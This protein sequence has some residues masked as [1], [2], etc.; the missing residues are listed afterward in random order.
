MAETDEDIRAV[1]KA[2]G[3]PVAGDLSENALKVRRNLLASGIVSLFIHFTGIKL[4]PESSVLGLKFIGITEDLISGALL[5]VTSYF[6][7]HFSWYAFEGV[8]EWR[9]RVTGTKLAFLTGA[10]FTSEHGDYPDDPR[11]S[12]L[13]NWWNTNAHRIGNYRETADNLRRKIQ[14]WE[15][16]VESF[17]DGGNSLNLSNAMV[18]LNQ[19]KAEVIKLTSQIEKT[20]EILTAHRIP[21]SLNRFDSWFKLFLKSQNIRWI[22]I[23]ILIPITTGALAILFLVNDMLKPFCS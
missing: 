10:R 2:L 1:E 15:N 22:L 4:H 12:T 23:E 5:I 14:E 19:A 18:T 21:F 13:Y 8:L 17:K 7:L 6:F 20:N 11:Q 3:N 9:L 16:R